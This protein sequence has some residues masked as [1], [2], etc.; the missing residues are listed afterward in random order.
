MLAY[1]YIGLNELMM[2]GSEERKNGK[3]PDPPKTPLARCGSL[4]F[5]VS[6]IFS[7]LLRSQITFLCAGFKWMSPAERDKADFTMEDV[8]HFLLQLGSKISSSLLYVCLGQGRAC[9]TM[10]PFSR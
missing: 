6:S 7:D 10:V 1:L 5:G 2:R 3:W 8:V 9:S 4:S